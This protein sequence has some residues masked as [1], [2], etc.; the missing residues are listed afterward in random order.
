MLAKS[1]KGINSS[2]P[3]VEFQSKHSSQHDN[4]IAPR[5]LGAI[6]TKCHHIQLWKYS[7]HEDIS[8]MKCKNCGESNLVLV[9]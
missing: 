9:R 8:N 1:V 3:I 2:S 7:E 5:V 4:L 6:C